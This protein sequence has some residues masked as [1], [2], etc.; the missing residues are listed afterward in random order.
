MRTSESIGAIAAALALFQAEVDNPKH[1]ADNPFFK[2]RYTPLNDVI[3]HVRPV[4]AKHGLAVLQ[5][6][7]SGEPQVIETVEV[8]NGV[9]K[10]VTRVIQSITVTTRL[11]HK[12]GEWIE[13]EPLSMPAEKITP[14]GAGSVIT[15]ARRYALSAILGIASEGDDD[16][17]SA[18]PDKDRHGAGSKPRGASNAAQSKPKQP[19]GAPAAK[20]GFISQAQA[21]RL[22]ALSGG[23][24]Q[25]VRKVLD[26]YNI[27]SSTQVPTLLYQ[28]ICDKVTILGAE[29]SQAQ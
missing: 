25:A 6:P 5:N 18:E 4:L 17:N 12:S 28:D 14:Q 10:K 21:R 9:E 26:E 13:G 24:E 2:S 29:M 8:E 23:N 1:S 11:V 22:F 7:Q 15:Y 19:E 16:G 3:N 20:D 27:T